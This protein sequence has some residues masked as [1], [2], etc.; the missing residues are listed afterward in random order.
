MRWCRT[1]EEKGM[2]FKVLQEIK[3]ANPREVSAFLSEVLKRAR[4]C[5][6]PFY[7]DSS[8]P[9]VDAIPQGVIDI[10]DEDHDRDAIYHVFLGG[11]HCF[12]I[13]VLDYAAR[14]LPAPKS[15]LFFQQYF[16]YFFDKHRG[17]T[18]CVKRVLAFM[19]EDKRS[20]FLLDRVA[21]RK[22]VYLGIE[23]HSPACMEMSLWLLVI[24]P[25]S[26]V[27]R[28][29]IAGIIARRNPYDAQYLIK[30]SHQRSVRDLLIGLVGTCLIFAEYD[31]PVQGNNF[32]NSIDCP[33]HPP[34]SI[35]V[36]QGGKNAG[37]VY[38]TLCET[39]MLPTQLLNPD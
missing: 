25:L 2:L 19:P 38:C 27:E 13:E 37:K 8:F 12:L 3:L 22:E 15:L 14:K 21:K 26:D 10:R 35:I 9:G 30:Y 31:D 28:T 7:G 6:N 29:E 4:S 23:P 32:P 17:C 24:A 18:S 20:A 36:L 33:P 1:I 11:L 39:T 16:D 5:A 34:N